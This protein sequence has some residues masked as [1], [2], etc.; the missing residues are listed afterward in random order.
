MGSEVDV[1]RG[2]GRV[3]SS[4][5]EELDMSWCMPDPDRAARTCESVVEE[6]IAS[7]LP[8]KA[9]LGSRSRA[10]ADVV[11]TAFESID[12]T[13][14]LLGRARVL[15][16]DGRLVCRRVGPIASDLILPLCPVG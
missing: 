9:V 14:P 4:R 12:F 10:G 11:A 6:R 5:V 8:G 16:R 7:E 2:M 1:D 3:G 13:L 15:D